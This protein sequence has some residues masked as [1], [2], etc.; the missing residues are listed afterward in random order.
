MPSSR[1]QCR[2]EIGTTPE[3]HVRKPPKWLTEIMDACAEEPPK[4]TRDQ[5]LHLACA[6]TAR[7]G[8]GYPL[9]HSVMCIA[10]GFS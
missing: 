4:G 3:R 10:I 1:W 6:V 2:H 5:L 7:V 9:D 8:A